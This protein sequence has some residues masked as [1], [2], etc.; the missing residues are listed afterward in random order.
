MSN[1]F[2]RIHI[3]FIYRQTFTALATYLDG[4]EDGTNM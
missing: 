4:N 1:H 3:Q 2:L